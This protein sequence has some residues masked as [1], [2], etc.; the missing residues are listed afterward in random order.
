M[1]GYN[2]RPKNG[3]CITVSENVTVDIV[4]NAINTGRNTSADLIIGGIEDLTELT[5]HEGRDYKIGENIQM[6]ITRVR[7]GHGKE[8]MAAMQMPRSYSVIVKSYRDSE[9]LN[10]AL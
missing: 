10:P 4:V 3:L 5:V 8:I 1:A 2:L 7:R 9:L 6:N